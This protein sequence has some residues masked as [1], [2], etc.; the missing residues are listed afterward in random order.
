MRNTATGN[1]LCVA[2]RDSHRKPTTHKRR[3]RATLVRLRTRGSMCARYQQNAH[4]FPCGFSTPV[5]L[6]VNQSLIITFASSFQTRSVTRDT[7]WTSHPADRVT[8]GLSRG[9]GC[10]RQLPR[11][12]VRHSLRQPSNDWSLNVNEGLHHGT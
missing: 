7:A 11:A 9:Y 5:L 3:S 2:S 12:N 8:S 4:A 10:A 6:F 1:G